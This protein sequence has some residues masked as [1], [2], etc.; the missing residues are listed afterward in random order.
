M[1]EL[2]AILAHELASLRR[3]DT[4]MNLLQA[5]MRLL[6]VGLTAAALA[7]IV[8]SMAAPRRAMADELPKDTNK[9]ESLTPEQAR[10]LVKEFPG[11]VVE[12]EMPFGKPRV[13]GCLPLN[14]LKSLNAETARALTGYD[15]LNGPLL[16]AGL[17]TLDAD[18]A[19]SLAE[20]KGGFLN[21]GGLTALDAEAAKALAAAPR[22]DGQLPGLTALDSPDSVAVAT[23]LATRKGPLWLPNLEK[24]SPKTLSA[25]IAKED[26]EIPLIE[27]L[28]LIP[29]PDGSATEDFV[30][31]KEFEQRQRRRQATQR[32][33]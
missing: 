2:D 21:L 4:P 19:K 16:L 3:H 12:I 22:W 6:A 29:E 17:T 15:R 32:A 1:P 14:G 27:T 25:L 13:P 26:V 9:I 18:T 10:K 23:A 33:E 20:F 11:V 30:V 31:T 5:C 8:L 7:V 28:E 24:I